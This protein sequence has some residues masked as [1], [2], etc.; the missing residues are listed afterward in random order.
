MG[1]DE[2]KLSYM[3]VY[4]PFLQTNLDSRNAICQI[5][6]HLKKEERN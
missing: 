1:V 4:P 5:V 6:L 3:I 2:E